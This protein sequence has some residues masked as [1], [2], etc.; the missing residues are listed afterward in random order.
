M[1][2]FLPRQI[3]RAKPQ[4][5]S[6]GIIPKSDEYEGDTHGAEQK[7]EEAYKCFPRLDV[8]DAGIMI[9]RG[10]DGDDEVDS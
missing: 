6:D 1:S 10:E 2:L 3:T 5:D 8:S 4:A 9:V 7:T